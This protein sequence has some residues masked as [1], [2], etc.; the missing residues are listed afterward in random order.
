MSDAKIVRGSVTFTAYEQGQQIAESQRADIKR[1]V[2]RHAE[3]QRA[4]ESAWAVVRDLA[5]IDDPYH[6]YADGDGDEWDYCRYCSGE[7]ERHKSTCPWARAR[8]LVEAG[9]GA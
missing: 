2:E 9:G 8:A 6:S 7:Y 1:A 3:Q 4:N 5:A